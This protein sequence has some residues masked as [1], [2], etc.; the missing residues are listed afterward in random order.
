M[1]QF[2]VFQFADPIPDTQILEVLLPFPAV[3]F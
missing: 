3:R 1:R 2:S